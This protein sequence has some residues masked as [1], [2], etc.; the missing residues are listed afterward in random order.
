[1]ALKNLLRQRY[2]GTFFDSRLL[3][4]AAPLVD[5]VDELAQ[6]R[7]QLPTTPEIPPFSLRARSNGSWQQFGGKRFV[8]AGDRFI[9]FL[10]SKSLVVP[11]GQIVEIGCGVGRYA[12]ALKRSGQQY[13][14]TG[15]DID[16]LS[17]DWCQEN[18][19]DDTHLFDLLDISNGA[20]NQGGSIDPAD[21][22]FDMVP[23]GSVDLVFLWSVFTHMEFVDISHYLRLLRPMLKDHGHAVFSALI[24]DDR[25]SITEV[26]PHSYNG[27]YIANLERPMKQIAFPMDL[28]QAAIDDAALAL[29][30][31]PILRAESSQQMFP[32]GTG[33]GQDLF[34]L[35]PK[36]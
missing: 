26:N 10:E 14:Y 20:Y 24:Y 2:S 18:I 3:K 16:A 23:D 4:V 9:R 36:S 21:V 33:L 15:I 35:K 11:G 31:P 17:I 13:R 27:G 7:N 22:R 1:M 30:E 6:K 5:H 28:F 32:K 29:V 25:A 19:A 12:L 8:D 34:L